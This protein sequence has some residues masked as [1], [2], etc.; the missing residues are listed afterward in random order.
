MA[1]KKTEAARQ[2]IELGSEPGI[3]DVAGLHHRLMELASH[4][5]PVTIDAAD[6]T[7][8]D[9]AVVQALLAFVR[10]RQ[11]Q[12]L[13]VVWNTPSDRFRQV[14]GQLGVLSAL[15]LESEDG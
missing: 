7:R 2:R 3:R 15:G 9:T 4:P 10:E 5:E 6:V 14:A 8:T 12:S 13:A 1:R 11:N